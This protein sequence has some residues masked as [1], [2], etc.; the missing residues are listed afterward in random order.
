MGDIAVALLC[1]KNVVV[2]IKSGLLKARGSGV[3]DA[4]KKLKMKN[5]K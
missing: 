5:E 4:Q 1:D 2:P 3:R